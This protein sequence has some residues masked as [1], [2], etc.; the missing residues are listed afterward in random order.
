MQRRSRAVIGVLFAL[1]LL[2]AA[3]GKSSDATSTGGTSGGG[4]APGTGGSA[5]GFIMVGPKDDYGYNQAVYEGAQAVGQANP[6][7]EILHGRERARDAR[8]R[9]GHGGH[10][11]QGRQDHL[12]HELRPPR[13]GRGGRRPSPRRRGRAPGRLT[14]QP[15]PN[16]GTYFGTVYEPVYLAGIAAG[17]DDRDE[18]ARLRRRPARS[19]RR[20][21][22]STRS[23]SAPSPSNPDVTTTVVFTSTWCDPAKQAEAA[24]SLLDQGIDVL[25]QH[26]DCTK[27]IVETTEAADAMSVGY[28]SDASEL[29][30]E[31]LGHRLGVELGSALHRHR[32]RRRS[33]ATSPAASTTP[34]TGS[35]SDRVRTRSSSRRS[36]RW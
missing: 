14:T 19:R 2:A 24:K 34:T 6:D 11:Q 9:A 16:F 13:R 12:R 36:A 30:P 3:C 15:V 33:P 25:T 22:T 17:S 27:T 29:A 21:R 7:L 4:S 26:Q 10:D 20:S 5:V 1:L 23:S 28:H 35:D 8:G 18:Q 31:G 32:R